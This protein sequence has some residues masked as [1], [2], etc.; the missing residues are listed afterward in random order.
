MS[1][2]SKWDQPASTNDDK[3]TPPSTTKDVK[4]AS[5][6]AAAAAAIAAKIA[7]QFASGVLKDEAA[8]QRDIDIN[9]VR[10]RY[11]LTKGSTQEEVC[12]VLRNI[13]SRFWL[14]YKIHEETGASVST[15][16]VWY[17]DR[18]KATEKDPPLYLHITA[19]TQEALQRAVDKIDGLMNLDLGPLV[20]DKKDRLREKVGSF[21]HVFDDKLDLI[22]H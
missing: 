3:S 11:M 21:S 5:D 16:G 18:S 6:A 7:A 17:P 4:S 22:S 14:Y 9:D 1:S 13:V 2:K 8:F 19:A 20:E 12:S 15:K 10:N